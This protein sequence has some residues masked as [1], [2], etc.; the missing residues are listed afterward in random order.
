MSAR[1]SEI[2]QHEDR[3]TKL[4][5]KATFAEGETGR[6]LRAELATATAAEN[7]PAADEPSAAELRR[8]LPAG[9]R[10]GRCFSTVSRKKG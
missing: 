10:P 6:A 3:I 7:G 2:A 8:G 5:S 9:E 1:S 4:R